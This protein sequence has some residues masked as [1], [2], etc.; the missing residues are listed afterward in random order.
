MSV[1][2]FVTLWVQHADMSDCISALMILSL[3][4]LLCM[5]RRIVIRF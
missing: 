4:A 1:N 2:E 5:E 3:A